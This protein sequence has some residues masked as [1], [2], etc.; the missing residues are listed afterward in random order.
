MTVVLIPSPEMEDALAVPR[1]LPSQGDYPHADAGCSVR[2]MSIRHRCR[3]SRPRSVMRALAP[4]GPVPRPSLGKPPPRIGDPLDLANQ[5][6]HGFQRHGTKDQVNQ[7][8]IPLKLYLQFL[9]EN[10][11]RFAHG[12]D[13][14][15]RR[16]MAIGELFAENLCSP[17]A[18]PSAFLL[19][20]PSSF[21]CS[22]H[23]TGVRISATQ[24]F[25][26]TRGS[27]LAL[28]KME[29]RYKRQAGRVDPRCDVITK[30]IA[31]LPLWKMAMASRSAKLGAWG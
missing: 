16:V 5:L 31:S 21:P 13:A 26:T 11:E 18:S 10:G 1:P 3:S 29:H 23:Q 20:R 22:R 12:I 19:K 24:Y 14:G 28:F 2:V 4:A 17:I 30:T 9:V 7:L 6:P 15:V 8:P 25:Q 27:P